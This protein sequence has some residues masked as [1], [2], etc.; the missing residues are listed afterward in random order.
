MVWIDNKK[1]YDMVLKTCVF[2]NVQ[3]ILQ[4]PKFHHESHEKL[5]G[6]IDSGKTNP[7]TGK[8]SKR[9][10]LGRFTFVITIHY[11]YDAILLRI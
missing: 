9:H 7:C 6:E 5:E 10:L 2:K 3:N 1:A 11:T 4:Y 8:N